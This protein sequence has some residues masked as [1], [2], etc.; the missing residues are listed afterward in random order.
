M[1]RSFGHDLHPTFDPRSFQLSVDNRAQKGLDRV[2]HRFRKLLGEVGC[3]R[4]HLLQGFQPV[5]N[6]RTI[7]TASLRTLIEILRMPWNTH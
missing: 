2:P 1:L 6:L 5:R 4:R 3:P 7:S